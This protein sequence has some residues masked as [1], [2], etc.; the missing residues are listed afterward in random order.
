M[1]RNIKLIIE[2]L[3]VGAVEPQTTQEETAVVVQSTPQ[4]AVQ[5][6]QFVSHLNAKYIFENFIVGNSNRLAFAAASQVADN[7]ITMHGISSAVSLIAF[8]DGTVNLSA[9]SDGSIN[10][11][12]IIETLGGGGHQ[13]QAGAQFPN[14]KFEKPPSLKEIEDKLI[15][16]NKEQWDNKEKAEAKARAEAEAKENVKETENNESN[17]VG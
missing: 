1:G 7:L 13:Y 17:S 14:K 9:R 6:E 12:T 3:D 11:H 16:M 5:E 2:S 15:A 10:I 4:A 8:A